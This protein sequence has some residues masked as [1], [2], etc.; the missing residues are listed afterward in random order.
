MMHSDVQALYKN[1]IVHF[2]LHLLTHVLEHDEELVLREAVG[3]GRLL[4][5]GV[6]AAARTVLHHQHLV[7]SVGL[8]G[9]G[10]NL[11]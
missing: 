6:E 2:F 4:Q 1:R 8:G 3:V 11:D 5:N 9:G 7:T 10:V